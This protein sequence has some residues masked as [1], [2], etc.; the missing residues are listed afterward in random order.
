VKATFT[1]TFDTEL[2]WGSFDQIS[3]EVFARR[4]PDVRETIASVLRL[5]DDFEVSATWAVVGHLFLQSCQRRGSQLAHPEL[6]ARPRQGSGTGD[7]YAADP[8]TDR[9]R[10]PL[11]YG[12]DILDA[13]QATRTP[14]EIGCHSFSH[15]VYGDPAM[16]RAAVDADLEACVALAAARGLVLRS[17][18]FPRNCEGHHEA[19]QAHGFRAYRGL[20]PTWQAS[21]SGPLGRAVRLADHLV[22]L[23]PPV[24]RPHERL[25]GL[26]NIPASALL[27][28]RT[29]LRR[30]VPTESQVRKAKAGLRRAK[31]VG[32]VFHLWTHPFNL[33]SDRK[34]MIAVLEAILR[35]AANARSR[36]ELVIEPMAS[37]AER[38]S[39][40]PSG[41]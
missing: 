34:S 28:P 30:V 40:M 4:Y 20:E 12:D 39:L 33:A 41:Q 18:V 27:I 9:R 19:L 16:T 1:L 10:D 7:W 23:P 29:G 13:L 32:G 21:L 5:L 25:P 2:I 11:W 8:C 24:S 14:Q 37:I 17:F 22:A 6:S 31:D 15:A 38:M 26:W 3:P 36:G 35:D